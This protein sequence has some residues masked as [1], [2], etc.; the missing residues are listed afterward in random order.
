MVFARNNPGLSLESGQRVTYDV[1][2]FDQGRA[3]TKVRTI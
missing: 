1:T 3:A 2:E